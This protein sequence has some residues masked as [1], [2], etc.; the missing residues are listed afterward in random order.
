MSSTDLVLAHPGVPDLLD[1]AAG[2]RNSHTIPEEVVGSWETSQHSPLVSPFLYGWPESLHKKLQVSCQ[3]QLL[4]SQDSC[5]CFLADCNLTCELS[6]KRKKFRPAEVA[7]DALA[8]NPGGNRKF[9]AK[10]AK[11]II[12]DTSRIDRLIAPPRPSACMKCNP[13]CGS[14]SVPTN[15]SMVGETGTDKQV[16]CPTRS[17]NLG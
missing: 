17:I 10:T 11:A 6:Q 12:S 5:V 15:R 4:E 16:L 9:L 13:R 2:G 3:Y 14:K 7:R 1:G 8:I